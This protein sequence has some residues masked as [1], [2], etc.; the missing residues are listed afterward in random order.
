MYDQ[1]SGKLCVCAREREKEKVCAMQ[2]QCVFRYASSR[3]VG[4]LPEKDGTQCTADFFCSCFVF[5]R[6]I[7][8]EINAICFI[9]FHSH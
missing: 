5:G 7:M 9:A 3:A 2:T 8:R 1:K 6:C 4:A